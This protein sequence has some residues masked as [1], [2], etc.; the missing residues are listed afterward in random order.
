[1]SAHEENAELARRAHSAFRT[2]DEETIREV[3]AEDV[4][5]RVPGESRAATVDHGMAEVFEGF[6]E[7][8]AMTDGTYSEESVDYLGGEN[9]AIVMAHV[10]AERNDETMEMDEIVVFRVENGQLHDA[11]HIPYDL[12]E[13]DA[14]FS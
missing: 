12:H 14:F 5:W 2:N 7:I 3:F 8:M 13:W 9:H 11:W 4:E 6:E 10:T 1:M